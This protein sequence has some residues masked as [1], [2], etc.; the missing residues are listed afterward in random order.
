MNSAGPVESKERSP[1]SSAGN[2][3]RFLSSQALSGPVIGLIVVLTFFIILI[4]WNGEPGDLRRFL[5]FKNLQVLLKSIAVTGVIS[6]GALLIIILGGIDLSVG[7]VVALV[8]VVIMQVF[9]MVLGQGGSSDIASLIA[10]PAGIAVG[11]A[12]GFCNGLVIT[13]MGVR[14]FV[15]TLGMLSI[16]RGLAVWL[17]GGHSVAFP[18]KTPAWVTSLAEVHVKNTLVN[19]GFWSLI[20]LAIAVSFLLRLTVLG[21]Y[22]YAIG[23]NETAARLCGI[24][25]DRNKIVIYTLAGLLT[26]WGGVLMFAQGGSG[27]PTGAVGLELDV[28][29]AVVI[30]GASLSGGRGTVLGT[31]LG[32]LILGVLSN[33]VSELKVPVE[34]RYILTGT[35]IVVNT[36]LSQWQRRSA[37]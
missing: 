19:P 21:R 33:G 28:I 18:G 36:A 6:L 25:I 32:V 10:V 20:G 31:I 29:A 35:I 15:T 26:G 7:S 24:A 9:R 22:C 14:P 34:I 3:Q 16:A 37:E 2:F 23:S 8:T 13:K 17:A 27:E 11:G 12:C 1:D 30:G 5:G 4:A